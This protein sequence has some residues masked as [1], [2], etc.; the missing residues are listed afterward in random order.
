MINTDGPLP[1]RPSRNRIITSFPDEDCWCDF[2]FRQHHLTELFEGL[3]FPDVVHFSNRSVLPGE[4]VFLRGMYELST[5]MVQHRIARNIFGSSDSVQSR[6]F[7][8]FID[9]IY[10]HFSNL[11]LDNLDWWYDEG[12]IRESANA[13]EAWIREEDPTQVYTD[14]NI[15]GSIDCNCLETCRVASGP[16]EDGP[17]AHRW[18]VEWQRA[19]FN[20]WKAANGLKHQ[21]FDLFHGFTADVYGPMSLRRND[22]RLLTDSL[23][24]TRLAALDSTL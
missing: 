3:R 24:N 2:R 16:A 10:D 21:T 11:V 8:A 19:F 22:L 15:G 1:A 17:G 23:L 20:A 7:L 14:F 12:Y 18:D 6:A 5:G 13:F 9:H 4:E